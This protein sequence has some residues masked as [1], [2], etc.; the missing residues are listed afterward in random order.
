MYVCS[1]I[2][3]DKPMK[4][5]NGDETT[6]N[7]FMSFLPNLFCVCI[8]L[9]WGSNYKCFNWFHRIVIGRHGVSMAICWLHYK[10]ERDLQ[11]DVKQTCFVQN[12]LVPRRLQK[13]LYV[14]GNPYIKIFFFSWPLIV[15]YTQFMFEE[16]KTSWRKWMGSDTHCRPVSIEFLH[17]HE[18]IQREKCHFRM[19]SFWADFSAALLT[20]LS[21]PGNKSQRPEPFQSYCKQWRPSG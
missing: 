12:K 3:G 19:R 18:E 13:G 2:N 1:W 9:S 6:V 16:R 21:Q 17:V 11:S 4:G 8:F 7:I 15:K 10:E 20:V 14:N 5:K